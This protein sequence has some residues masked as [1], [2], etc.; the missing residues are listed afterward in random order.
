[1]VHAVHEENYTFLNMATVITI[2][3]G[4][5]CG[6]ATFIELVLQL[7]LSEQQG[8]VRIN[9]IERAKLM[10]D[11][12][13]FGTLQPGHLLNTNANLMGIHADEPDHF[14]KWLN[15]YGSSFQNNGDIADEKAFPPRKLYGSYLKEQYERY[16]NIAENEQMDVNIIKDTAEDATF[17]DNKWQV[18]LKSGDNLET[19]V[20]ILALGTPK[21]GNYPEF[22]SLKNYYD[23]PWPTEKIIN[24]VDKHS[25]VAILGSS[26]SAI[27]TLMTL[28]DNE[29]RGQITLYSPDG[30]MP[31][32]Q[33][34]NS[35]DY[36]RKHLTLSNIHE[37]MRHNMRRPRVKELFRLFIEEVKHYNGGKINWEESIREGKSAHAL[38]DEDIRIAENGGDAWINILYSMRYD[39]S[40]IWTWMSDDE[41]IL[42]KKWFGPNWAV[43]RHGIPLVNAL[44]I[45][46]FFKAGQLEVKPF[47]NDVSYDKQEEKFVLSYGDEGKKDFASSL[48][49][50]TGSVGHIDAMDED[51]IR[52]LNERKIIEPY[53]PGG[54]RIDHDSMKVVANEPHDN[55]YALGHLINGTFMDTN[56]VWFNVRTIAAMC[57][58]IT[59][60]HYRGYFS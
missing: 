53:A 38:L 27:D 57:R 52:N 59:H 46:A 14:S 60:K 12:L 26:L 11:G 3:G 9:I 15:D 36:E 56:A 19:D 10:A 43:H 45:V 25:D 8:T 49:N 18:Q 41:K 32:V 21:P 23:F 37:L 44:K 24:G 16:L 2:V 34:V 51:L 54:I 20:L 50:A 1:M 40:I 31:R 33:P 58:D 30:L 13:A 7:K 4:G 6:V 47:L 17:Q 39:T 42:F 35:T 55:L 29:H 48:I 28:S 22:D 5:A